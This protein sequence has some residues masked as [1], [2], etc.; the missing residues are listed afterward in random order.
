MTDDDRV[1]PAMN[2]Q[3][4]EKLVSRL[5]GKIRNNVDRIACWEEKELEDADVAVVAYGIT[6]RVAEWAGK[7]VCAQAFLPAGLLRPVVAWPFPQ[8]AH[9]RA[10]LAGTRF[11]GGGDELRPDGL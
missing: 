7:M 1:I 9:P 5:V 6:S 3:A 11:R 8:Q 10:G 2:W 4:Q